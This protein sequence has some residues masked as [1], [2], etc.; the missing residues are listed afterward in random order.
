MLSRFANAHGNILL[1]DFFFE[2]FQHE[3][4]LHL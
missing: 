1:Y 3:V 4:K 2:F